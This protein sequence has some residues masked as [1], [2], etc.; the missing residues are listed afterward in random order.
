MTEAESTRGHPPQTGTEE[1]EPAPEDDARRRVRLRGD[2]GRLTARRDHHGLGQRQAED[3][4]GRQG[5]RG[6]GDPLRGPGDERAPDPEKVAE[7]CKAAQM[8]G[9]KVIIAGAGMS[10]ALPGVAAA[11]TTC[12]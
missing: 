3:A 8:R 10:A 9:L 5:A 2:R 11:H 7:Y 6:G 1:P 4:A 12:R